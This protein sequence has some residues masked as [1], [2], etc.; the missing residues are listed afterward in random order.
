MASSNP[1]KALGQAQGYT[2]AFPGLLSAYSQWDYFE[3]VPELLWPNSIRTYTRMF[4]E[5]ARI[6]S[7]YYA[8][9]LPIVQAG[10]RIARNGARDEVVE[11]VARDLRLPIDGE[12]EGA[13]SKRSGGFSWNQH[14]QWALRHLLF[15]HAVFETTYQRGADGYTHLKDLG[16]RPAA[17]LAYWDV[18]LA[19]ELV[20]VTQWPPGSSFGT[21]M[22]VTGSGL[23]GW[24]QMPASRLVVY[25][26]DM[27]PGVWIGNSILRPAYKN[28]LLKDELIRIEA[29]A[30]RR[31]GVG[32]PVI[33]A[34]ESVSE[35]QVGSTALKPYLDIAQQYRGGNNAGVALPFGSEFE[36]AGVK[37]TLP[38]GFIRQ[39]IEYHDKQM[40]LA[41]LAHFLNL[42]RGGSYALASVQADT[43]SQGVQQV[44]TVMCDV[45]Q[46]RI[47]E[48][49]V[50][51]NFG[52]D[53]ATPL[54]V[55][56]EI[57]ARQ[58][59]SAQALQMLVSSGL[60]TPDPALEAYER[61]QMGLPPVH[62]DLQGENP[63][64][65][66][67]PPP[68]TEPIPTVVNPQGKPFTSRARVT[69]SAR[70]RFTINTQG[71]LTLW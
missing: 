12:D 27:D 45:A 68:V 3:Q 25:V 49:L 2:N 70:P 47:V 66:P 17:T 8:I 22:G 18:D 50:D 44:A 15:G 38:S 14:L 65:F 62:P 7:V 26:R 16:P 20:G 64:Q 32:V 60:L 33:T 67:K 35:A 52:V 37:G 1:A 30:A 40:A 42:D 46:R 24:L 55:C 58:D 63:D 6:A 21:P 54:L 43:F 11:L 5:E 36:L 48:P 23:A 69:A 4:R 56:D 57:G 19:G 10:W 71:D 59:A 41:A 61:Q 34:P 51:V 28:W 29:T 9:S 53:E 13:P 39:A 31:N